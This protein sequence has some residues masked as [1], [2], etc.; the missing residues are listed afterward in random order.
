MDRRYSNLHY[1]F[2]GKIDQSS[3][4]KNWDTKFNSLV[5]QSANSATWFRK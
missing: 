5:F 4:T 2:G 3:A 1:V